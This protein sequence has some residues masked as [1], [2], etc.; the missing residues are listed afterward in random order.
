MASVRL[1][2]ETMR[3]GY[4]WSSVGRCVGR[5]ARDSS[6]TE[7]WTR[8]SGWSTWIVFRAGPSR[9]EGFESRIRSGATTER[10]SRSSARHGWHVGGGRS[11]V[12]GVHFVTGVM[13]VTWRGS[14]GLEW[15]EAISRVITTNR[16]GNV[17]S[18]TAARIRCRACRVDSSTMSVRFGRHVVRASTEV[19]SRSVVRADRVVRSA[20][21]TGVVRTSSLNKVS[22][23]KRAS[24]V[25][26]HSSSVVRSAGKMR[27][28]GVRSTSMVRSLGEWSPGMVEATGVRPSS[29]VRSTGVRPSS[30]VRSIGERSSGMVKTTDVRS[31]SMVR[32]IG[33]GSSS[34]V[35]ATGVRPSSMVRS[36][37]QGSSG[38]VMAP[39]VRP[40]SMVRSIS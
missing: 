36:I 24:G 17:A 33:E 40:A 37:S 15:L 26:C 31:P 21:S 4:A 8:R 9:L 1:A 27:S 25:V 11:A 2:C 14:G 34:M 29:M 13:P 35:K 19:R 12:T 28:S 22:S 16:G 20:R 30:K 3:W 6:S 10:R 7:A 38:M 5:P 32:S 18:V 23:V 39:G